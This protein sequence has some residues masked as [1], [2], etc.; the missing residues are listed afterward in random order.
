MRTSTSVWA[1][2]GA[3]TFVLLV[4]VGLLAPQQV[5][6]DPVFLVSLAFMSLALIAVWFPILRATYVPAGSGTVW[7]RW[8]PVTVGALW[9]VAALAVVLAS[10]LNS[11]GITANQELRSVVGWRAPVFVNVCFG[12]VWAVTTFASASSAHALSADE[13]QMR[14]ANEWFERAQFVTLELKTAS[15]SVNPMLQSRVQRVVT[16]VSYA[17]RQRFADAAFAEGIVSELEVL[18]R[19]VGKRAEAEWEPVLASAE[20]KLKELR[21]KNAYSN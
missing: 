8:A 19:C 17:P 13:A 12:A 9:V 5:G 7:F 15:S 18:A 11:K 6:R 21:A 2:L 3:S 14:V 1:S 16:A 10:M 20:L 4:S